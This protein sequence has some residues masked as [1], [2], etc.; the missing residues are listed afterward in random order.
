MDGADSPDAS[1]RGPS[2]AGKE[3]FSLTMAEPHI[4]KSA[5]SPA[6]RGR[7]DTLTALAVV[8]F[9]LAVVFAAVEVDDVIPPAHYEAVA[10]IIGFILNAGRKAAARALPSIQRSGAL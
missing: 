6:K 5:L 8:F 9:L 7:F 4:R 3:A 10:K 1:V 2:G